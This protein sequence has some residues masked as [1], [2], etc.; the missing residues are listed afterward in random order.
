MFEEIPFIY[1]GLVTPTAQKTG[2]E[3]QTGALWAQD[4]LK[5]ISLPWSLRAKHEE[6]SWHA[7]GSSFTSRPT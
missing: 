3:R 5:N 4:F 6:M 2:Q 1:A 7:K